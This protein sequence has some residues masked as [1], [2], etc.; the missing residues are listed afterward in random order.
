MYGNYVLQQI[1]S[2]SNEPYKS[3]Y[4]KYIAMLL[5]GLLLYPF[6][7]VVL[8]KLKNTFPELNNYINMNDLCYKNNF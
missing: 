3:T 8:Y 2:V 6:G 7:N 1:I 5:N 4:I